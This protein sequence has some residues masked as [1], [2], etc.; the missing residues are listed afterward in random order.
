MA[1]GNKIVVSADPR[2]RFVEGI[3]KTGETHYPG[4]VVQ[5]DASVTLVSNKHTWK[6]YDRAAD[7]DRP[8]GPYI[9][10]IE[11][12]LIGKLTT[13]SYAAG[14]RVFGYIPAAGDELNL[15]LAD[16]AGTGDDHTKGE[17]LM[18]DDGTGKWI[19]T[20]GSPQ[21]NPA[22]LLETVTDPTSTTLAW[23]IWSGY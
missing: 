5:I 9:V 2:G 8:A 22:V 7:G 4:M 14:E 1:Q 21:T 6:L 17:I 10:I 16:I 15:L 20:T 13:D 11:N 3:V 18:V 23:C 12:Y 19:A